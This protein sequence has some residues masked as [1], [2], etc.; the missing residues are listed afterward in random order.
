MRLT[1]EAFDELVARAVDELP[2]WVHEHMDNI[3]IVAIPWPAPYQLRAVQER[4]GLLLGLYEGVPLTRRGR[5][6]HLAPPDRITLFQGPLE[7]QAHNDREL[8]E[9]I[10]RTIVHEIAHHFGV[11]S[12]A[13]L[14]VLHDIDRCVGQIDRLRRAQLSRPYTLVVLSDH[15]LTPSRPFSDQYGQTLG[16]F[17]ASRLGPELRFLEQEDGERNHMFQTRLLLDEL[18][19]IEHNL[20]PTAS[21]V[22]RRV[23]L[24]VARRLR[25]S[26]VVPEWDLSRQ[27]DL[28]VKNS[29]SLA[30]LYLQIN[31]EQMDVSEISAAFPGLL[32]ALVGHPG[33]WFVA[34]REGSDTL[35]LSADGVLTLTGLGAVHKEGGHPLSVLADPGRA[36]EQVSRI[37]AYPES[38]DLIVMGRY[39][40]KADLVTTF[41]R[42]WA[43]HGGLGGAQDWPFMLLPASRR[44]DLSEVRN[45]TDLYPLFAACRGLT[46]VGEEAL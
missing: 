42:Q 14:Q 23:R 16:Q 19:A 13:A 1:S 11:R 15:G 17:V 20:G 3:S 8:V 26:A 32:M 46:A 33:V 35:I 31:V 6:Y 28:V 29:G 4:G 44:W 36:A 30:H 45:A 10:R 18:R 40:P 37:L 7:R 43:S 2:E 24:L 5:G 39:E 22:A 21:K 41:E 12:R 34:G 25:R 9:W 27:H 38:G